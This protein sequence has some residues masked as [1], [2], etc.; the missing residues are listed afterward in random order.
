MRRSFP[1][2]RYVYT[3]NADANA[4][5]VAINDRLGYLGYEVTVIYQRPTQQPHG[6]R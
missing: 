6:A 1:K 3:D 2:L 4:H 5:M